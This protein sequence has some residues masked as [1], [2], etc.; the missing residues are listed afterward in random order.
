MCFQAK[1]V[2][3]NECHLWHRRF[4][5]LNYKG[6]KTLSYKKMVDGLPSLKT[7]EKLCTACLTGKQHRESIPKKSLLRASNQLQL[8]HADIC[9]P[10]KPASNSDKRYILSFIDD[11]TRKTWV[12]FLHEK[13]EAFVTFK[14][15]KACVEKE[16]GTYITCLRTDRGW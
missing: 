4:G 12:Y 7:P 6:L 15:F 5:H 3:E 13:S 2:S 8:V 1:A 16:I 9:G 14:N 11:L 10:V